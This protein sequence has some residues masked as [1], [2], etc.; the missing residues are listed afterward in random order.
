MCNFEEDRTIEGNFIEC[1]EFD[2]KTDC[3]V[4]VTTE[5]PDATGA[6][7]DDSKKLCHAAYGNK[8]TAPPPQKTKIWACIFQ[9]KYKLIVKYSMID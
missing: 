9:S 2:N 6:Y 8:L 5:Y 7:W 1:G 4:C 3:S